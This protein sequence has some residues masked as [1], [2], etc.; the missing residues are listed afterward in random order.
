M[1]DEDHGALRSFPTEIF[2]R[3]NSV[4]LPHPDGALGLN[5]RRFD[6]NE[7]CECEVLQVDVRP[8][9]VAAALRWRSR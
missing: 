6:D 5:L 1:T 3:S 8:R 4:P 9:Y 2:A 7:A